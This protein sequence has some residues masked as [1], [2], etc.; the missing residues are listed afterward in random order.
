MDPEDNN[1]LPGQ[2]PQEQYDE[3]MAWEPRRNIYAPG[4]E[5]LDLD[6]RYNWDPYGQEPAVDEEADQPPLFRYGEIGGGVRW[7]DPEGFAEWPADE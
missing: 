2:D 6:E 5:H 4:L 7:G 1:N 3:A